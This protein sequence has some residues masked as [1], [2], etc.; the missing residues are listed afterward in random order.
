MLVLLVVI[1]IA[2]LVDRG[3]W[4]VDR[5]VSCRSPEVTLLPSKRVL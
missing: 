3:Q 1:I 2:G 5:L 4:L